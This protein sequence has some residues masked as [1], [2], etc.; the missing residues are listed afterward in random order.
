MPSVVRANVDKHVGH[1]SP[2]PGAFHQTAYA[3]PGITVFVN[4]EQVIRKGD[5]T[6]CGDPAVGSATNVYAED[7]LIHQK[8]DATGGHESWVANK[9]AS[10]SPDVFV[11][12]LFPFVVN[13]SP[14]YEA[15]LREGASTQAQNS[16]PLEYGDGGISNGDGEFTSNNTS[17]VNGV[18]GPQQTPA[19]SESSFERASDPQLNFLPHTD[20]RI[21]TDLKNKLIRLAKD[22]GQTLVITSG[23][24]SPSYNESL[25]GAAKNSLHMQGLA[26]DIVMRPYSNSDRIVFIEKAIQNGLTGIGVYNTFI[27][28]DIGGKRCWGS[29]GSRTSLPSR[30]PW[31]RPILNKYGYATS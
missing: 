3:E 17:P 1:E 24:R 27:H 4:D 23:Y 28:V 16:E 22:W 7:K 13:I 9:A 19:Q 30:A 26:V 25:N 12:N 11:D 18:T 21:S 20:P 31:A 8:G 6:T 15:Y 29:N 14:E 2:T 10:G 5:K